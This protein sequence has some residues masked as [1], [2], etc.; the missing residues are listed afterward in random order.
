MTSYVTSA[1]GTKIAFDQIGEGPSVVV[2]SGMFCDRRTTQALAERLAQQFSVINYDRRGRGESGDT[3]PYAVARE[4]EDVAAL[5]DEVGGSASVYSHSSGAGLAVHAA[6]RGLPITRLV[7]HEPPYGPDD[8][9]SQRSA[10]HLAEDVRAAV[11]EDRR[12]DAIKLFMA[13]SGMPPEMIDG[14]STDAKM[15]AA[16]PTMTYDLEVMGDFNGGTIPDDLVRTINVPTLVIAGGATPEFFRDTATRV[17]ELLPH[18][19]HTVLEG[20]DHAAP[21]EVVAPVVAEFL[22]PR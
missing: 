11:A 12:A 21:A 20:Q 18:G 8:E 19:E 13:D 4:V 14:M 3:P 7:L 17:T 22:A 2:V 5:I 16:A 10:R 1:D 15:Q 9:E 6:A